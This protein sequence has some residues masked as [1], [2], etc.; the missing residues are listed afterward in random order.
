MNT[1][2]LTNFKKAKLAALSLIVILLCGIA[3]MVMV[4]AIS[5][6]YQ[7][8]MGSSN[9]FTTSNFGVGG[10]LT[11]NGSFT[12]G[13][14][15]VTSLASQSTGN[16]YSV[17]IGNGTYPIGVPT[18]DSYAS[19][20]G[21]IGLIFANAYVSIQGEI[22]LVVAHGGGTI[23]FMD[24]L[25]DVSNAPFQNL[26]FSSNVDR[27][28]IIIPS[29]ESN[30]P[31][32][33]P[34]VNI[35]LIAETPTRGG[36]EEY[37]P[38]GLTSGGVTILSQANYVGGHNDYIFGVR[39][40]TP[41]TP[42]A[43]TLG[44]SSNINL[45]LDGIH[46]QT[47]P[48]EINGVNT[49]FAGTCSIGTIYIDT[50]YSDLSFS[51]PSRS[52]IG[53]D[54]GENAINSGIGANAYLIYV[55]GYA[56]GLISSNGHVAI[57]KY[58]SQQNTVGLLVEDDIP[59]LYSFGIGTYSA[60][61][62]P[63]LLSTIS[64]R[65]IFIDHMEM[66]DSQNLTINMN[67][68]SNE[69]IIFGSVVT[70][71]EGPPAILYPIIYNNPA[72][73]HNVVSVDHYITTGGEPS[74][75]IKIISS[76]DV[77]YWRLNEGAGIYATDSSGYGNLG[78]LSGS[79]SMLWV[80]GFAGS[81]VGAILTSG[82]VTIPDSPSLRMGL[83]NFTINAW[84]TSNG[85]S[86]YGRIV[87]KGGN[88]AT[89][90]AFFVLPTGQLGIKLNSFYNT[91]STGRNLSDGKLHFVSVSVNRAGNAT[92]YVDGDFDSIVDVSAESAS[93]LDGNYPLL[94]SNSANGEMYNGVIAG[95]Q[96]SNYA[97]TASQI[98]T[99][100]YLGA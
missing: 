44:G 26:D 35:A 76:L 24:G 87:D 62:T 38:W 50:Y 72:N 18:G 53:I 10:D 43:Y 49:F 95:V 28:Q 22:N 36:W 89:G 16:T 81:G 59:I 34:T 48:N 74:I 32:G 98:Q 14:Q 52:T 27:A 67:Y 75:S 12:I 73:N 15:T 9:D 6:P 33:T 4:A 45:H 8:S 94:I 69:A 1:S 2:N 61:L 66:G 82:K 51:Y 31:T 37:M 57:T 65:Q 21:Q 99:Q 64:N 84:I 56:R 58:V 46:F 42:N 11:V 91:N 29:V 85:N 30:W 55:A 80:S 100:F 54:F 88:S 19:N 13:N 83:G 39:A 63:T 17:G 70:K 3:G 25:Y 96:I 79:G 41:D 90:Y 23:M 68:G 60:Q 7:V 47:A 71:S 77:G 20:Y 40:I 97:E 92:F 78:V 86:S 5:P 93:S